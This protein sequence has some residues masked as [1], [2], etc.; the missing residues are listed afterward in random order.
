MKIG[1]KIFGFAITRRYGV[2]FPA[3]KIHVNSK[4]GFLA[5]RLWRS[6]QKYV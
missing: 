6:E 5:L 2:F 1:L 3:A 4:F